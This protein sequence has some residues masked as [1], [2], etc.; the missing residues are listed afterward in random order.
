[1]NIYK[2]KAGFDFVFIKREGRKCQIKF[3]DTGYIRECYTVN[4]LS[5]KVKDMYAKT[6]FGIGFMGDY[7]KYSF[8]KQAMQLWSN[9]MKRCYSESD[10]R[11]YKGEVVVDPRWHCFANFIEDIQ[12]LPNFDKWLNKERYQLD[13]DLISPEAKCYSRY[14]CSFVTEEENKSA[15]KKGKRLV[16]GQWVTT[17]D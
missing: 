9:M 5:G 15:G 8:H 10:P 2:N 7:S 12:T 13:K 4:A 6:R 11:G 14:T 16:D 1:M 17:I 3:L